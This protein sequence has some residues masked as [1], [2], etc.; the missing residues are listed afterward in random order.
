MNF[1]IEKIGTLFDNEV[2]ALGGVREEVVCLRA[3]LER[4]TAFLRIADALQES[5][6][7][8]SVWVRQVRDIAHETED[9]LAEYKLLQGHKHE[10][11]IYGT[12]C[13]WACCIK[14]A[15]ACYRIAG[16][17]KSI[18]LRVKTIG[19][20]HKRLRDKFSRAEQG[21]SVAGAW[22]D[23]RDDALLLEKSDLVGIDERKK[24]LVEWLIKG[25]S[26]RKVVSLAGQ[27]G[28]GKT[29]LAKQV[30]D[31]EEVKKHFNVRAWVTVTQSFEIEDVLR[32]M[33]EQLFRAIRRRVPPAVQNMKK[34]PLK[35]TINEMLQRRRYLIVLDDVWQLHA[36]HAVQYALPNNT[37]GSRVMLTTRKTD[38]ANSASIESKGK[39]YN[40]EPLPPS[41]S[42]ELL[43]RKT[44]Q[45]NACPL[46]LEEICRHIWRKCEGLPLV[47]SEQKLMGTTSSRT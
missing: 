7:E 47:V 10:P 12:L 39:T 30:Y 27:G 36:W 13:R 38:V 33:V 16:D 40:L 31:D 26:G 6:E 42:W 3:E 1:L 5:D 15:K 43:C 34:R 8:L 22:Q 23:R 41:D 37:F 44:F 19:E 25:G 18:N 9:L 46:H 35:T 20:I 14:N 29:T 28:M 24:Q 11:G 4:M 21:S 2:S 32:D 45:G 17:L